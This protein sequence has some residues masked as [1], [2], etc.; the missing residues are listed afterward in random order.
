MLDLT[1]KADRKE[2]RKFNYQQ[3]KDSVTKAMDMLANDAEWQ[4]AKAQTSKAKPI[5]PE[6]SYSTGT[7]G[8]ADIQ[9]LRK[10][11][12]DL[13][14]EAA[15]LQRIPVE[16][17]GPIVDVLS[18]GFCSILRTPLSAD[19]RCAAQIERLKNRFKSR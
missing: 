14:L 12:Q 11:A 13:A 10:N 2:L 1:D 19:P 8:S 7:P 4:A 5:L 9:G 17:Q 6:F 16:E 3:R 18:R 15:G